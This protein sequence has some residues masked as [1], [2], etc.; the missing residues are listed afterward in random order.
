MVTDSLC[1]V[2]PLKEP[3]SD[4]DEGKKSVPC[5]SDWDV[6][7]IL[8]MDP[9]QQYRRQEDDLYERQTGFASGMPVLKAST[10]W[11]LEQ[12]VSLHNV[13]REA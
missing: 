5:L 8:D 13:C 9:D 7:V 6:T 2:Q 1:K 12:N 4:G 3:A 11:H 10:T